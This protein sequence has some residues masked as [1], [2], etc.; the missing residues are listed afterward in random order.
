[1]NKSRRG[2]LRAGSIVGLTT[3]VAGPLNV[4]AFGQQQSGS[5]LGFLIPKS[6]LSDPLYQITRAAF[7]KQVNTKFSFSLGGVSLGDLVLR[8]VM[9]LNPSSVKSDGTGNR[10]CFALVFLGPDGLP[11]AQGTYSVYHKVFGRFQLF[12]VPGDPQGPNYEALV[13]RLIP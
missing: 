6:A 1:M 9:N 10:D 4:L 5:G 2:F 7:T 3:I 12:I 13:N 8:D 11:L